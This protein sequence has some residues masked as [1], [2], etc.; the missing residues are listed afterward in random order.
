MGQL[1]QEVK[2]VSDAIDDMI[3]IF[4]LHS[5]EESTSSYGNLLLMNRFDKVPQEFRDEV[6]FCFETFIN[7]MGRPKYDA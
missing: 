4:V 5:D 1:L 6:C 2:I 3:D 7:N